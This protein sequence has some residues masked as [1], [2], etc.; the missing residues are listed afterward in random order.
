[1]SLHSWEGR[2]GRHFCGEV[3]GENMLDLS[4]GD[5]PLRLA[6][7]KLNPVVDEVISDQ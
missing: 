7:R 3:S 6:V 5:N 1:M 4:R 2:V